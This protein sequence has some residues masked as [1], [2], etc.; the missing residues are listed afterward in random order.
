VLSYVYQENRPGSQAGAADLHG[1]AVQEAA[2]PKHSATGT[3]YSNRRAVAGALGFLM[4]AMRYEFREGDWVR[5]HS[6]PE[7]IRVI[8]IGSTIAVQFPNGDMQAF[9]P[10]ELEKVSNAKI[11]QQRVSIHQRRQDRGLSPAKKFV[12]LATS[13]G[14]IC[15]IILVLAVIAGAGP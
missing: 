5:H 10:C 3:D 4:N 8:G 13:I 7:P 14:L 12:S 6:C 1:G 2:S 15:L 9:E 11:P